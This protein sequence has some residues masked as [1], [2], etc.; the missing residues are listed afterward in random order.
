[1]RARKAPLAACVL[2][3]PEGKKQIA[4]PVVIQSMDKTLTDAEIEALSQQ[5]LNYAAKNTGAELRK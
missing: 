2:I 5:I 3:V 4:V 1:M